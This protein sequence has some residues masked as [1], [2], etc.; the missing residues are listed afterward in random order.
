[1]ERIDM[2]YCLSENVYL[3]RGKAKDCL[4]D[5]ENKKLYHIQKELSNLIDKICSTDMETLSLTEEESKAIENLKKAELIGTSENKKPFPDIKKLS[6]DFNINFVWI[7]ICTFCNLKC[8]HCYNESSAQC[9]ETMS[10]EDFTM[11]CQKL[12]DIGVKKGSIDWR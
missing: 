8:K 9:H 10:F 7:E 1:M 11:V 6:T 5:L 4:Y 12:L 3:V 2:Y